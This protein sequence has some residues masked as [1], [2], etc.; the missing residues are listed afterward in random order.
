MSDVQQRQPPSSEEKNDDGSA[1]QSE[2]HEVQGAYGYNSDSA[3]YHS[4]NEMNQDGSR[5][6]ASSSTIAWTHENEDQSTYSHEPTM[7]LEACVVS[8]LCQ[9]EMG[10]GVVPWH[11]SPV[12]EN[13]PL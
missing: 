3:C 5:S 12:R 10:A 9:G 2:N 6:L 13:K 11:P 1:R 8:E 4:N 7:E